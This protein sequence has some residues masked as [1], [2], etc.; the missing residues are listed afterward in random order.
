MGQPHPAARRRARTRAPDPG[1]PQWD[2]ARGTYIQW[3]P[4]QGAW[5]QWNEG[6]KTWSRIAGSSPNVCG[7]LIVGE[8]DRRRGQ[9]R[10]RMAIE[11]RRRSRWC[12]RDRVARCSTSVVASDGA[13]LRA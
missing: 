2:E 11:R 1:V 6:T 13:S 7:R 12:S 5:M 8:I 4:A 10:S 9:P 3:D